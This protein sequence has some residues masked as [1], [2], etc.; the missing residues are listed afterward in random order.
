MCRGEGNGRRGSPAAVRAASLIFSTI[1]VDRD[2]LVVVVVV[3]L[4]L[5]LE[6]DDAGF[7]P[8][9]LLSV[10]EPSAAF[11]DLDGGGV[12]DDDVDDDGL[13]DDEEGIDGLLDAATSGDFVVDFFDLP[14]LL[15]LSPLLPLLPE[16]LSLLSLS[17]PPPP[18]LLLTGMLLYRLLLLASE[19]ELFLLL[20]TT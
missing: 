10:P 7:V 20:L 3:V 16:V 2:E 12:D 17:L 11:V 9:F 15:S 1:A 4:A 6:G 18:S 5:P 14:L 8:V 19:P 13:D